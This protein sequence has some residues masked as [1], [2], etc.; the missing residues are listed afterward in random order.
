LSTAPVDLALARATAL[1]AARAAGLLLM[2]QFGRAA[3]AGAHT[4]SSARDLVTQADLASEG[5]L[6][7]RLRA[8]FPE[9]AI[10]AE[11]SGSVGSASALRWFLDPLDGTV[12]FVHGLPLFCVSVA[13]WHGSEP[14]LGVVH[15]PALGQ[16]FWAERGRGAWLDGERLQVSRASAL[17]ECVL[18]TGFP[19]RRGER[20]E[21]N[22]EV[23]GRFFYE[24][25]DLRRM[26][27]AALDLAWVAAGKLDGFWELALAPHDVAAGA[28]LVLE[29]GGRVG[30]QWG[31]NDWLRGGSLVAAPPLLFEA[32]RS[33][34]FPRS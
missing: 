20:T 13:L 6:L 24:V 17:S 33:R 9:H 32:L 15:A 2:D 5:E 4:K 27:S 29:A 21:N 31:G 34:L 8:A 28:L 12:N 1:A 30:D 11:E 16:T 14:L 19:Y 10:E 7:R 3:R 26:G 25:R 22:L 18:A 23:C